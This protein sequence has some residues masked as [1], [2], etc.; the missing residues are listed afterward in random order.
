MKEYLLGDIISGISTGVMQLPQGEYLS[1]FIHS[2]LFFFCVCF[3]SNDLLPEW[4]PMKIAWA[5]QMHVCRSVQ[6]LADQPGRRIPSKLNVTV[7]CTVN[8]ERITV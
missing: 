5:F 7:K 1:G 8:S 3:Y 2:L 6:H 4:V